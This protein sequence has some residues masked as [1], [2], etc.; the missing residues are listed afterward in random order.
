M[1]T[2]AFALVIKIKATFYHTKNHCQ[3][4]KEWKFGTVSSFK[5]IPFLN[6]ILNSIKYQKVSLMIG[7]MTRKRIFGCK[8]DTFSYSFFHTQLTL[9]GGQ[10]ID[11]TL[12]SHNTLLQYGQKQYADRWGLRLGAG[13]RVLLLLCCVYIC[14]CV[15]IVSC[16]Y[17]PACI[18][19][20]VH[21]WLQYMCMCLCACAFTCVSE[22][23][24]G[25]VLRGQLCVCPICHPTLLTPKGMAER[26]ENSFW[27]KG[28]GVQWPNGQQCRFYWWQDAKDT[29]WACGS[30]STNLFDKTVG[31]SCQ[32]PPQPA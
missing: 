32:D 24:V 17:A 23:G 15:H 30:Q 5:E 20:R 21:A 25:R 22:G 27:Q 16:A 11:V 12:C 2:K 29:G 13:N 19:E 3:K 6:S 10:D 26:V 18:S 7:L 1:Q 8:Y 31:Y 28:I 9:L 14:I 4:F